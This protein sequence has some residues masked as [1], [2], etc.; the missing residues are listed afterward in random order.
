MWLNVVWLS[1]K[2]NALKFEEQDRWE[3]DLRGT[4]GARAFRR[5][6]DLSS[7]VAS[8]KRKDAAM[9][10]C[11]RPEVARVSGVHK[12]AAGDT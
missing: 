10:T 7:S 5:M 2:K 4:P 9:E 11:P 1:R 12:N 3:A 8:G 6:K